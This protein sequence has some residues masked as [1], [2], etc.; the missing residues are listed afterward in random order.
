MYLRANIGAVVVH[1][2]HRSIQIPS[3]IYRIVRQRE[4]D[5]QTEAIRDVAD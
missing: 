1:D 3:G 5:A 2:E 4:Y